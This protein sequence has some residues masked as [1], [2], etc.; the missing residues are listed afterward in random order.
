MRTVSLRG[1]GVTCRARATS[2]RALPVAAAAAARA[3]PEP[4]AVP[5]G[6]RPGFGSDPPRAGDVSQTPT[7]PRASLPTVLSNARTPLGRKAELCLTSERVSIGSAW[8]P[9]LLAS[10][11]SMTGLSTE[12]LLQEAFSASAWSGAPSGH[13]QST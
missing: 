10:P 3:P 13:P 2:R 8:I 4:R 9:V 7:R 6:R 11:S 1:C 12:L 5:G